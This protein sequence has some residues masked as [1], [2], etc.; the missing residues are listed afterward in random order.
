M[1]HIYKTWKVVPIEGSVGSE[2]CALDPRGEGPYTGLSDNVLRVVWICFDADQLRAF[3]HDNDRTRSLL[4]AL[5]LFPVRRHVER[6]ND[7]HG[8][9][10]EVLDDVEVESD[11]VDK[12]GG[13]CRATS[14]RFNF[15]HRFQT[16]RS[17]PFYLP[18]PHH[19]HNIYNNT[20]ATS[21]TVST[22]VA[23]RV[24]NLK[25]CVNKTLFLKF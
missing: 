5:K 7:D 1:T 21:P 12:L 3:V 14:W 13:A 8:E 25:K 15:S 4:L 17:S 23:S 2:C 10:L 16:L 18:K 24:C 6:D 22:F 20:L 9:A 19:H 11:N